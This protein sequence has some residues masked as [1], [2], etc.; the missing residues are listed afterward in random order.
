M[1]SKTLAKVSDWATGMTSSSNP[2]NIR[3]GIL[4]LSIL[5]KDYHC[6]PIYQEIFDK[7]HNT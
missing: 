6:L 3:T 2:C 4:T 7:N 5:R 1:L